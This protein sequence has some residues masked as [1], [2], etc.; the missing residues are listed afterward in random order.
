M[1]HDPIYILEYKT[2]NRKEVIKGGFHENEHHLGWADTLGPMKP[3]PEP[4]P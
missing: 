2:V 4:S 3:P 1:L